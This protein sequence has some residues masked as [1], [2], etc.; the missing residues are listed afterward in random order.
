[1]KACFDVQYSDDTA[2]VGCLIFQD[3]IDEIPSNSYSVT[4]EDVEEYQS[5]QFYKRELPCLLEVLKK[6]KEPVDTLIID[7]HV[8]LSSLT[9]KGLGAYLHQITGLP[10]IG[11]AKSQFKDSVATEVLRGESAR[12]LYVTSAGT[13][14]KLAADCIKKM[15][16]SHR[17]PTL[18]KAVDHVARGLR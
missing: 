13:A 4:I 7:G 10:V 14:A 18:L 12:P 3:W 8:W 9:D 1:M 5:G 17:I 15:H 11:V 16:G 2:Q 6:V